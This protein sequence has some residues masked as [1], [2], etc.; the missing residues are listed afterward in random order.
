MLNERKLTKTELDK[1]EDIIMSM[2]KNK[3]NLVKKYGKDAEAVMYGRATNQAK[4]KT[5]SMANNKLREM[6]KDALK[7]PK[8]ADLNKDGKI[9]DYE[10][11]RGSA[12]EKNIKEAGIEENEDNWADYTDI[13]QSYLEGFGKEHTLDD[14]QL[15]KLGKTIVKRLY[16]GD[17]GKAYDAIVKR[18]LK[19]VENVGLADLEEMGY[20][21]A[22]DFF[23][24]KVKQYLNSPI[25]FRSYQKGLMQGLSDV[26]NSYGLNEDYKPSHRAYNVIDKASG[27]II[28][29]D[30]PKHMALKLANKKKGW[31]ISPT[32]SLAEDLDLGHEDNEP[33]MLK[34]DL[35]RIGKYAMELYQMMDNLEGQGEVDLPHWWQAKITNAKTG[36]VGAK[37]YLDFEINEPKIDGVVDVLNTIEPDDDAVD[38]DI[39]NVDIDESQ[40]GTDGDTGFTPSLYTPNELGAVS[41]DKE[42]SS[43]AFEEGLKNTVA[44]KLAKKL[45]EGLPKGFFDKAMDAEDEGK[46]VAENEKE[47]N[48]EQEGIGDGLDESYD[49]LVNKLKKQG[50]SK[51]ASKAIAGAVASYKAKGGGKGP[52]AK[53]K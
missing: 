35:Y 29:N 47:V 43:G 41:V 52:T 37:H 9:S 34:A 22:D 16:K 48:D 36:I 45:K 21:A 14:N 5:E 50:K 1:R 2:K 44:E 26:A 18:D 12:I 10:K 46:K 53:Q 23:E 32:D 40:L 15:E 6:V 20:N 31:V 4:N 25:D 17:I 28:D 51:K 49:T 27:E 39:L 33:H 24:T 3:R 13:G 30:L 38:T 8:A 42:S 7:N 11:A 19:E